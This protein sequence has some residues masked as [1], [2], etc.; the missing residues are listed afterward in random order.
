MEKIFVLPEDISHFISINDVSKP[1]SLV[2]D[3]FFKKFGSELPEYGNHIV[4]FYKKENLKIPISYLHLWTK[5]RIGYIGGGCT[6]GDLFRQ[7]SCSERN[8]ISA[9]G[10]LLRQTLR[11]CFMQHCFELDAFF[12]HCGNARAKEVDLA[13]GFL[14]TSIENLLVRWNTPLSEAKQQALIK[15]AV[16]IGEF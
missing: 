13:A 7:L 14:E 6:D 9:A 3:L 10:G 16:S 11:Y 8:A 4:A 12:G 15:E 5:N 2:Y 1:D